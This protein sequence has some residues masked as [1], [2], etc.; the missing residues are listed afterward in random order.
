[1]S[2]WPSMVAVAIGCGAMVWGFWG[3]AGPNVSWSASWLDALWI[4]GGLVVTCAGTYGVGMD[5]REETA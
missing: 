2:R 5:L 1:M 4:G 3:I